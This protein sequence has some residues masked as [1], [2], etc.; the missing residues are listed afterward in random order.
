MG[1]NKSM[2]ANKM[3][4]NDFELFI[5]Y[6]ELPTNMGKNNFQVEFR[7]YLQDDKEMKILYQS[8]RKVFSFIKA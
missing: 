8:K 4:N 1:V 2:V 5:P 7:V 6:N 3:K